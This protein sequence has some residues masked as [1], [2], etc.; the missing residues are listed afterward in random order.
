MPENSNRNRRCYEVTM[1]VYACEDAVKA[2]VIDLI[3]DLSWV[4]GC[5]DPEDPRFH[6]LDVVGLKVRRATGLDRK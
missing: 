2:D 1:R 5:R 3:R 4:G 6:S